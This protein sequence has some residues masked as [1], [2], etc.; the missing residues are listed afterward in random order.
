MFR[1][2]KASD[3]WDPYGGTK[4]RIDGGYKSRLTNNPKQA[5]KYW[6]M[7]EVKNPGDAAISVQTRTAGVEL[8][9]AATEEYLTELYNQ[10][11]NPYKLD[12]LIQGAKR[13]VENGCRSVIEGEF[14]DQV[15]PFSYG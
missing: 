3:E 11:K 14:G 7:M 12:Y 2:I 1:V 4:Y 10:Y 13:S 9:Q 6:F 15:D 5:I 8:C